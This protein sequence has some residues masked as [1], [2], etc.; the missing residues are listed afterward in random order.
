[1]AENG[2]CD[3]DVALYGYIR[4]TN[5][6]AGGRVHVAGVG[7]YPIEEVGGCG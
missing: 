1:V 4:G 3:R 2:K 6:K 5:W 7:D